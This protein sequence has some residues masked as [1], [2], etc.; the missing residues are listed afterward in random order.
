MD[1][2]PVGD[3]IN[4]LLRDH[5][6]LKPKLS[7]AGLKD[8]THCEKNWDAL[9]SLTMDVLKDPGCGPLIW[10][11]GTFGWELLRMARF[12]KLAQVLP[13]HYGP[14]NTEFES[15]F[16]AAEE[17]NKIFIVVHKMGREYKV[18]KDGKDSWTGRYERKGYSSMGFVANVALEHYRT[19]TGGFGVRVLQNKITPATDG[20][21]LEDELCS[22]GVLAWKIWGEPVGEGIEEFVG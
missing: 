2:K 17:Y 11:T 7:F 9:K 6:I 4:G 22:F 10:D 21:E 13:H 18:G 20:A 8:K 3:H 16:Y 5:N 12:G 1:R 15:I 19:E 14:V